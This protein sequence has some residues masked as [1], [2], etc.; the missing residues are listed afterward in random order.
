[1]GD[2]SE[3]I[4]QGEKYKAVPDTSDEGCVDCEFNSRLMRDACIAQDEE[5]PG[6]TG[7]SSEDVTRDIIWMRAD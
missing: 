5:G 4:Y 1:M 2:I 3:F 6:C 7:F